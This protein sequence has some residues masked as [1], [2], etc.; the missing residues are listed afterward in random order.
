M[1]LQR[2]GKLSYAHGV[3]ELIV[4]MSTP[5]KATTD[6]M[7]SPEKYSLSVKTVSFHRT[8]TNNPKIYM[9]PE[10]H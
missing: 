4:K 9:E 2:S 10:R 3:E 6:L 5:P 7:Q 1:I 8:R